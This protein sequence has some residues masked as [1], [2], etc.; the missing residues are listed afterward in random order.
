MKFKTKWLLRAISPQGES[1]SLGSVE[2][3]DTE[4]DA[5]ALVQNG[6]VTLP[7]GC[8]AHA[9]KVGVPVPDDAAEVET[10]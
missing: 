9:V 10:A 2:L 7:N 5:F 3:Q 4:K 8:Y 1:T 6:A